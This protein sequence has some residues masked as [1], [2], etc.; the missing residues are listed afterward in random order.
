M[1]TASHSHKCFKYLPP[2][3]GPLGS[4][5]FSWPDMPRYSEAIGQAPV[6]LRVS[7]CLVGTKPGSLTL[8]EK[9][10]RA[11]GL[12]DA[13][14]QNRTGLERAQPKEPEQAFLSWTLLLHLS[15][16]PNLAT[17][18]G[19][20]VNNPERSCIGLG[21]NSGLSSY[22][23]GLLRLGKKYLCSRV[24]GASPKGLASEC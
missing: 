23:R 18:R 21:G 19:S 15:L 7:A 24:V 2:V 5:M 13:Q 8:D 16:W 6:K 3:L 9:N 4:L 14:G 22:P 20:L 17:T 12:G 10:V 11:A 1:C